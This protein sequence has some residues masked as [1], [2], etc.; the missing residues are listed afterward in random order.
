M[1]SDEVPPSRYRKTAE[2]TKETFGQLLWEL[3][4][5]ETLAY[6]QDFLKNEYHIKLSGSS[7]EKRISKVD[8]S[9]LNTWLPPL[10]GQVLSRVPQSP[11]SPPLILKEQHNVKV[12]N[13]NTTA[14][15]YIPA[16]TQMCSKANYL[17]FLWLNFLICKR[18][19]ISSISLWVILSLNESTTLTAVPG[20]W[21]TLS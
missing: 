21:S 11:R 13:T 2:V 5:F 19:V 10:M 15:F 7:W 12:N 4:S 14:S 6:S 1:K 16:L 3:C 9:G 8:N 17:A 18:W 20:A